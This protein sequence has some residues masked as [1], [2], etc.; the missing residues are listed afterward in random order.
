MHV[1]LVR[2]ALHRRPFQPFILRLADGR[3]VYVAAPGFRAPSHPVGYIVINPAD[4]SVSWLEPVL[5]VSIDF[6]GAAAPS[7]PPADGN[8]A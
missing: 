5:I 1:D 6:V 2:D 8:G 3:S 7:A 4:E